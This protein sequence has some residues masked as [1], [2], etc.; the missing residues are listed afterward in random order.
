LWAER[1][2]ILA[3]VVRG[4][5]DW[6]RNG[7]QIPEKLRAATEEYRQEED[8]L[9]AFEDERCYLGPDATVRGQ[10][11]YDEYAEWCHKNNITPMTGTAFGRKMSSRHPKDPRA[12]GAV[13]VGI[14]LAF[15][16]KP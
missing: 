8:T 1:S 15:E 12:R 11:L 6:Q 7:L 10:R 4:C 13:Y 14:G 5:L 2:G 3:W 16:E 9:K